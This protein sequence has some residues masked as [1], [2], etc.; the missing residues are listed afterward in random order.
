[1]PDQRQSE[2][3]RVGRACV[4]I[5]AALG[6]EAAELYRLAYR[7]GSELGRFKDGGLWGPE[8]WARLR[9]AAERAGDLVARWSVVEMV[10]PVA[11]PRG[12]LGRLMGRIVD[13]SGR[14]RHEAATAMSLPLVTFDASVC[15][16]VADL[17]ESL[18]GVCDL[19][20]KKAGMLSLYND[21]AEPQP[22][23][24]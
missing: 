20:R 3:V 9:A 24:D 19:I 7:G 22:E 21:P 18:A 11:L 6:P 5:A 12:R 4:T 10:L 8:E 13:R 16:A 23:G 1:M 15:G 2:L 14:V 17:L